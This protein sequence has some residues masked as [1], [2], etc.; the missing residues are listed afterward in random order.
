[1]KQLQ[2]G[3]VIFLEIVGVLF[4]IGGIGYRQMIVQDMGV[5]AGLILLILALILNQGKMKVPPTFWLYMGFATLV[6]WDVMTRGNPFYSPKFFSLMV[7]GGFFWTAFYLMGRGK[8]REVIKQYFPLMILLLGYVFFGGY[9][10]L[11]GMGYEREYFSF[12]ILYPLSLEHHHIGVYWSLALLTLL[13]FLPR[14]N[15]YPWYMVLSIVLGGYLVLISQARSAILAL[16]VGVAIYYW[17]RVKDL[18]DKNKN[19]RI[20]LLMLVAAILLMSIYKPI[21]LMHFFTPGIL[22]LERLPMGIGV[23][24]F[25]EASGYFAYKYQSVDFITTSTHNLF[26]EMIAGLGWLGF[27]FLSW[28]G[29]ACTSLMVKRGRRVEMTSVL[30]LALSAVFV[31]DPGYSIPTLYWLWMSLLGVSQ[32][33]SWE[34]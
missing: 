5:F 34:E 4:L 24:K 33:S 27:I 11:K 15:K 10:I 2:L 30:F 14:D 17:E 7:G 18:Q 31:V 16:I 12:S 19:V 32:G 8:Y 20:V 22:T 1:M 26:M 23:G 21:R 25:K 28:F 13:P 6:G 3:G 9:L 29:L